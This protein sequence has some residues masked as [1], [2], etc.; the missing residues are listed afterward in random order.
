MSTP[1]KSQQELYD[2]FKNAAQDAAPDLTDWN[3]GSDL[4]TIGGATSVAASELSSLIIDQ[5]AK[6]FISLANGPE[7][8]GGPDDLQT[9]VVDH[10]GEDFARPEAVAAV[11]VATFTRANNS[12]GA[13]LIRAGTV[14]KTLADASGNVQRYATQADVTMTA[15]SIATDLNVSVTIAALVAGAAGSASANT[16]TVIESTLLDNTITV[17]NAGN[18][19]GAG[20]QD[21]SDYRTTIANLIEALAGATSTAVAAKAKTVAGVVVATPVETALTVI[22]YDIGSSAVIGSWFMIPQTILY[23]ADA[24]GQANTALLGEVRTA[25]EAVKAC[26]VFIDVRSGSP[27]TINWT[28]KLTLN[29]SGP[30]YTELSVDGQKILDT[31]RQYINGLP[32]GTGFVRADARTAILAIWGSGGTNDLTDLATTSPVGDT[33]ATASQKMVAGTVALS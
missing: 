21:D 23:V 3:D 13:V 17:T 31:M 33:A 16:I 7:V 25:I 28:V 30:N 20:A 27:I 32:V 4:D 12:R 10:F 24:T 19:T 1:L 11:D 29:P 15:S 14:V 5:F 6:T 26:G 8:T 2:I 22:Q 9:L 18:A